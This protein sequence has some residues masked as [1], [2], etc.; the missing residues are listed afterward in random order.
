MTTTI[1]IRETCPEC[2]GSGSYQ[3]RML[4]SRTGKPAERKC[5]TCHG[6]GKVPIIYTPESWL[7]AG[8]KLNDNLA[9]W[10]LG[11]TGMG[12]EDWC[13]AEYWMVR[14][15]EPNIKIII[16]TPAITREVLEG[17]KCCT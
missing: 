16:D 5:S 12:C 3:L 17:L 11:T 7:A 14:N 2:G 1:K 6:E 8:Y 13:L 4:D 10:Y 15:T 9:V